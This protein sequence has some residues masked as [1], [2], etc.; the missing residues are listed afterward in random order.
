MNSTPVAAAAGPAAGAAP[1]E[2]KEDFDVIMTSFGENKVNIA[3]FHLGR[4][5]QGGDEALLDYTARFDAT[6]IGREI[7]FVLTVKA[8]V[9]TL[10]PCSKAISRTP[11]TVPSRSGR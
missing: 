7:D 6:A 4:V 2:A 9:T 10:C 5:K 8:T 11:A 3:T 1:V